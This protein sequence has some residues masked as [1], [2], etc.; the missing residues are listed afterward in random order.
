MA[1]LPGKPALAGFPTDANFHA[2]SGQV[3]MPGQVKSHEVM[4][5]QVMSGQ[6]KSSQVK[7]QVMSSS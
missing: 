6:V 2:F 7:S 3:I 5:G 4:S 1:I